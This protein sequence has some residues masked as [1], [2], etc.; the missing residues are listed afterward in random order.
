MSSWPPGGNVIQRSSYLTE[1]E[2][3]HPTFS[4]HGS[5]SQPQCLGVQLATCFSSPMKIS[6]LLL[7]G[8]TVYKIFP[9]STQTSS[10]GARKLRKLIPQFLKPEAHQKYIGI[11]DI[12][13]NRHLAMGW[14]NNHKVVVFLLGQEVHLLASLSAVP[15]IEDSNDVAKLAD[16]FELLVSEIFYI[17]INFPGTAFN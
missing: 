8:L 10:E 4:K 14:E 15:K 12:I 2:S 3:V 7:G 5:R 17:P 6:L 9:Y 11:M 13:A 16:P 1:C